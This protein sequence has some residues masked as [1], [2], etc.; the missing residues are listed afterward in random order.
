MKFLVVHCCLGCMVRDVHLAAGGGMA[1]VRT[2][3][4]AAKGS[5]PGNSLRHMFFNPFEQTKN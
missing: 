4:S 3:A 2:V 1:Q 5:V